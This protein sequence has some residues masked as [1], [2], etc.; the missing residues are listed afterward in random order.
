MP[1]AADFLVESKLR[2]F[3]IR[4]DSDQ[5][6]TGDREDDLI[7][8]FWKNRDSCRQENLFPCY[9]FLIA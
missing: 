8:W 2:S 6:H 9:S 7:S 1:K 3:I 5:S 4:L